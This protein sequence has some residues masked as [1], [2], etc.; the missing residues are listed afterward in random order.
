MFLLV[1][2]LAVSHAGGPKAEIMYATARIQ[3]GAAAN[4]EE[5][6]KSLTK[7]IRKWI[8]KTP[9]GD[10]ILVLVRDLE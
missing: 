3:R 8:E 7:N 9:T 2:L 6:E 10:Q 5:W 1:S 4:R